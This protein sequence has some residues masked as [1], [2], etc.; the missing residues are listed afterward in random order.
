MLHASWTCPISYSNSEM[1]FP[2]EKLPSVGAVLALDSVKLVPEAF[3]TGS[4][5][6][7]WLALRANRALASR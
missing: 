2:N 5:A 6:F 1:S 7:G 4:L 3:L